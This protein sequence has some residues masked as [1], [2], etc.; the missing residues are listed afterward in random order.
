MNTNGGAL[1][2]E[3]IEYQ[4]EIHQNH[5]SSNT[6]NGSQLV[7]DNT[8]LEIQEED[9]SKSLHEPVTSSKQTENVSQ[10]IPEDTASLSDTPENPQP[11]DTTE[12]NE[13]SVPSSPSPQDTSL[14][15]AS[16]LGRKFLV[17][18]TLTI[19]HLKETS[20]EKDG[21][22]KVNQDPLSDST[23]DNKE[24]PLKPIS[25]NSKSNPTSSSPEPE[26]VSSSFPP[27]YED[28][29]DDA[30]SASSSFDNME[31]EAM[32]EH[33]NLKGI[34]SNTS[35]DSGKQEIPAVES[36]GDFSRRTRRISWKDGHAR[37]D[38]TKVCISECPFEIFLNQENTF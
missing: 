32:N 8:E 15:V 21:I 28:E 17:T 35:N 18:R 22:H 20:P 5:A 27:L 23:V 4:P 19:N 16:G 33:K 34:L 38:T 29:D 7:P 13:S 1:G 24:D 12:D 11:I 6:D 14:P 36:V 2:T 37:P 9:N 25:E 26:R 3:T 31:I 10:L 30:I